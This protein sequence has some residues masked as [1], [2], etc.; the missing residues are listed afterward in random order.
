MEHH[1]IAGKGSD[2]ASDSRNDRCDGVGSQLPCGQKQSSLY[3]YCDGISGRHEAAEMT[4]RASSQL[5]R[6]S[7]RHGLSKE[8]CL[9][10]LAPLVSQGRVF[11]DEPGASRSCMD[12]Q[13]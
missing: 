3:R 1:D 8:A 11:S 10:I 5:G 7:Q 12:L 13:G 2:K 6:M 4:F 9:Q